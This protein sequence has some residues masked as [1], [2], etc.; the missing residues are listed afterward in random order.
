MRFTSQ[1]AKEWHDLNARIEE[2]T[3]QMVGAAQARDVDLHTEKMNALIEASSQLADVQAR[4]V[5]GEC[6]HCGEEMALD[7]FVELV[8]SAIVVHKKDEVP[9]PE[10][11]ERGL[12][13]H[14]AYCRECAEE[15]RLLFYLN[16]R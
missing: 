2:L 12:E 9:Q 3:G 13:H 15:S 7:E 8:V 4:P 5:T 14:L 10:V 6:R 11:F 16:K 1:T